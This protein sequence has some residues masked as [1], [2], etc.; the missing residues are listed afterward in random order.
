MYDNSPWPWCV[1]RNTS[2]Q[3]T[4]YD[5][6]F[7]GYGLN[8]KQGNAII[9]DFMVFIFEIALADFTSIGGPLPLPPRFVFGLWWSRY[10][11]ILSY[12]F[13]DYLLILGIAYSDVE[14]IELISEYEIHQVFLFL[15]YIVL[16]FCRL[17]WTYSLRIWIGIS[18]S[19]KKLLKESAIKQVSLLGGLDTLGIP[20]SSPTQKISLLIAKPKVLR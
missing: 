9:R 18:P 15:L 16:T 11:G 10:W 14:S 3:Q 12:S 2:A 19:T 8:F 13:K 20:T 7:L 1:S 17:L 4:Y 5:W 6:Y